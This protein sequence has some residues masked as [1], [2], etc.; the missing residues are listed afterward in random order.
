MLCAKNDVVSPAIGKIELQD[1][2][3]II[4]PIE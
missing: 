4:F 3:V 1:I 2:C